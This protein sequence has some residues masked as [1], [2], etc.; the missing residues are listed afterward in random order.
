MP[1]LSNSPPFSFMSCSSTSVP[2]FHYAYAYH[3]P[4]MPTHLSHVPPFP[5]KRD[6]M[7][8]SARSSL[9]L[10]PAPCHAK[11]TP[12]DVAVDSSLTWKPPQAHQGGSSVNACRFLS[13]R[14]LLRHHAAMHFRRRHDRRQCSFSSRWAP[15]YLQ[16]ESHEAGAQGPGLLETCMHAHVESPIPMGLT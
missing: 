2:Y 12:P 3:V 5:C 1:P 14:R 13:R 7:R 15:P 16:L 10:L 9:T 4:T 11:T 6:P 8:A